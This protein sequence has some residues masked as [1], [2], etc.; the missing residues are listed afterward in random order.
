[1]N[2]LPPARA[3]G[4]NPQLPMRERT[5]GS[6][7]GAARPRGAEPVGAGAGAGDAAR[8]GGPIPSP[9]SRTLLGAGLG[10][11]IALA[12]LA[13]VA[14]AGVRLEAL[15]DGRVPAR[16]EG[17]V[18]LLRLAAIFAF[19]AAGSVVADL[20]RPASRMGLA[21][22][23]GAIFL[24][25]SAIAYAIWDLDPPRKYLAIPLAGGL[26]FAVRALMRHPPASATRIERAVAWT[27]AGAFWGSLVVTWGAFMLRAVDLAAAA[28][29]I[30]PP[31]LAPKVA[32]VALAAALFGAAYTNAMV[33]LDPDAPAEPEGEEDDDEDEDEDARAGPGGAGG[34]GAG[35]SAGG[36]RR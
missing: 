16:S 5:K 32:L 23:S 2:G 19:G 8:A 31:P 22:L 15:F 9:W 6:G 11:A 26:P 1:M 20:D 24:V 30:K 4:Y 36:A 29:E 7:A 18:G 28:R 27:F 12:F 35:G 10:A 21:A 33:F 14:L 13:G 34:P 3:S 17:A 25:A